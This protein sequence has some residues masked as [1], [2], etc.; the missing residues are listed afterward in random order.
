VPALFVYPGIASRKRCPLALMFVVG[1][2]W[3]SA[4][5]AQPDDAP[6]QP[7]PR[8]FYQDFR[9]SR[10][11]LPALKLIG[12]D[13][14]TVVKPEDLGLRITLP[15]TRAVNQPIA[16]MPTFS[17]TGD[18]EITGTYELL[19]ADQP[20]KG[21][22]VGVNLSIATN[23]A[24]DR[25][26]KVSR[27]LRAQEG[28]V[29]WT[30]FWRHDPPK[31]YKVSSVPSDAKAGQLRLV[32][33]GATVR[34]LVADGRGNEFRELAQRDFGA[35][36]V[37]QVRFAVSDSG[38]GNAIDVRLVDLRIRSRIVPGAGVVAGV[39]GAAGL[40]KR[41]DRGWLM[42]ALLIGVA[43]VV[44]VS[45]AGAAAFFLRKRRPAVQAPAGNQPAATDAASAIV[46]VVC[47]GCGTELKAKA[48][49][50]GKKI[51]CPQCGKAV[52]IPAAKASDAE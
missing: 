17:L 28:S 35:E 5:L 19:S 9:G 52:A 18:F 16:V 21:Y 11:L 31:D 32:R 37:A 1:L 15:K 51:K 41:A 33:A 3:T 40:E 50:A 30:E 44:F 6:T 12:P 46:V 42:A 4:L 39:P 43:I 23:E 48:E 8:E 38:P 24:W 29:Y 22:G 27:L 20:A 26:G 14:D 47:A 36:D 10:P 25:F 45:L 49:W 2:G 13:I 7:A 34:F